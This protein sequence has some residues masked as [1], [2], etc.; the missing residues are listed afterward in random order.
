MRL[1]L[2]HPDTELTPSGHL[3]PRTG[4]QRLIE[5]PAIIEK[6]NRPRMS[7]FGR[8]GIENRGIVMIPTLS[9]NPR[10]RSIA[11]TEYPSIQS[12]PMMLNN[13][14]LQR[15][16]RRSNMCPYDFSPPP[17]VQT[18][19]SSNMAGRHSSSGDPG[20][21]YLSWFGAWRKDFTERQSRQ[22]NRRGKSG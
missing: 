1:G 2:F 5:R 3:L 16:N 9:Q 4:S 8:G 13:G 22:R 12:V 6:T 11:P 19:L 20:D 17:N 21:G 18:G 10:R 15:Q 7:P 14:M